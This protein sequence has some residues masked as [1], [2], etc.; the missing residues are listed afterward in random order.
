[1]CCGAEINSI[2]AQL[3]QRAQRKDEKRLFDAD[4]LKF[5]F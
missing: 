1:M 3:M 5:I 4:R 2:K